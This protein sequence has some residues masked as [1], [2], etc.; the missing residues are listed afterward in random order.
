MTF[1]QN[2]VQP[3]R[4]LMQSNDVKLIALGAQCCAPLV[5]GKRHG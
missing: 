4:K 5:K 3:L 1:V 2:K